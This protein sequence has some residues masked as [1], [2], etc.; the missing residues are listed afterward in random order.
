[1]ISEST[2]VIVPEE[3]FAVVPDLDFAPCRV[4]RKPRGAGIE[5][6][7]PRADR[8]AGMITLLTDPIPP[9]V[10][11]A[12]PEL[13]VISNCAVGIDN[14]DVE[15]ATRR[16]IWITHTPG[17][18][19]EATAD[20]TWALI[21]AVTRRIREANALLEK[22]EYDGWGLDLLL[23]FDLAGKILGI[24]G[25]GRIGT[26]VAR[27][28]RAFGMEI[29][30]AGRRRS[31]TFERETDGRFLTLE[32]LLGRAHVVSVHVP[33]EPST[34]RLIGEAE[35]RRMRYDGVL[36][37]TSRG[38]VVDESALIHALD[39]GR[40]FGAGLD[41][42][43]SE[44]RIPDALKS[45]WNVVATPHIGSATRETRGRMVRTARDNLLAVLRGERPPNPFNHPE[46]TV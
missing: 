12:F 22:E 15:A 42:F 32:D 16:G 43:E 5:A 8:A 21:L 36:I 20:L 13:R 40:I 14:I 44:P 33:L 9:R 41:V 23:G 28:G 3:A 1:M 37:N 7:A 4:I 11:D 18:L 10:L 6:L 31:G 39:E 29:A 27:R 25:P 19:T 30:Y 34:R 2:I 35:L 46:K 26:A 17:V 45:R 24:V 38:E